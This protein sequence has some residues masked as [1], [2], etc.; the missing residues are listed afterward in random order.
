VRQDAPECD[1]G[2][3]HAGRPPLSVH[4]MASPLA[5]KNAFNLS[6]EVLGTGS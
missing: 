1:V 3:S 6:D 4:L 5:L 2:V